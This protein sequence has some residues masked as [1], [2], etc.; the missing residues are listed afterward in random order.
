MND[1][2]RLE[3]IVKVVRQYLP[4]DGICIR[5]AMGEIIKLIDPMD[6][7]QYWGKLSEEHLQALKKDMRAKAEKYVPDLPT[8]NSNLR[9]AAEQ[10]LEAL[11]DTC[12]HLPARSGV[13]REVDDA[14]TA[15]Q[16][17]LAPEVT[18]EVTPDVDNAYTKLDTSDRILHKKWVGLTEEEIFQAYKPEM[19]G[20]PFNKPTLAV[21]A[22]YIEAR[23]EEKNT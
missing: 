21:I 6:E 1:R 23:L 9:K 7:D 18:P 10:A 4:P 13:E 14:I 19:E 8:H 20:M 16:V 12:D 5:E 11:Q 3:A 2:E 17:A 22:G 15:L